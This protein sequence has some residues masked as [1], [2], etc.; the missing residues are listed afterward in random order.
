MTTHPLRSSPL[1]VYKLAGQK[2]SADESHTPGFSSWVHTL[3]S[4]RTM[5]LVEKRVKERVKTM[6]Y[7]AHHAPPHEMA[8]PYTIELDMKPNHMV[9]HAKNLRVHGDAVKFS[10][11]SR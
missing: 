3:S 2:A 5:S 7:H 9:V 1:Q 11:L 6:P 10:F 4:P 8:C